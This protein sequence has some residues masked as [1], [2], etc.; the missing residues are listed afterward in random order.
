ML[1]QGILFYYE[2]NSGYG[3]GSG[4][5]GDGFESEPASIKIHS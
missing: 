3:S 5:G 1:M 2:F 4:G